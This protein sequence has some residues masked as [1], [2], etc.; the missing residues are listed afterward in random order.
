LFVKI[1]RSLGGDKGVLIL[2]ITGLAGILVVFSAWFFRQKIE[3]RPSATSELSPDEV[4][5]L[6]AKARGRMPEIPYMAKD[7]ARV[8]SF[9]AVRWTNGEWGGLP[10]GAVLQVAGTSVEGRDLWINGLVQGGSSKESVR[11]HSSFLERYLPVMLGDSIELSDVRLV[12]STA[13]PTTE[14][15][16]T[17]WLRNSTSQTLSQCLVMCT[18]Q[19][20]N[21]AR[22]DREISKDLVLRPL[23]FVRF[24]TAP[25]GTEK[26][27]AEITLEISHATAEGLR[28]YLPAVVIPHSASQRAQ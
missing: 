2:T 11:I 12:H 13:T 1:T 9:A 22:L 10:P 18:F 24:E 6:G 15:T 28:N 5:R 17:G 23:Q 25:T 26:Q 3:F 8:A 7:L 21:G 14:M 4:L 20:P 16:V 27:F 19:D